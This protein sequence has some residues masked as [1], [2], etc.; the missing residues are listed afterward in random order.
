MSFHS[1]HRSTPST[2][3]PYV[4]SRCGSSISLGSRPF[5]DRDASD[6]YLEKKGENQWRIWTIAVDDHG[7]DFGPFRSV[8][9]SPGLLAWEDNQG[10]HF[11]RTE[12]NVG[13]IRDGLKVEALAEPAERVS[14]SVFSIGTEEEALGGI[15]QPLF[16]NK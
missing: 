6:L 8:I 10:L 9:Y 14:G 15:W 11:N 1:G 7:E 3:R 2:P 5:G 4:A 12:P 13:W 16:P